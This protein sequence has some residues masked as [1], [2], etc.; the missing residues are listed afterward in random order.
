MEVGDKLSSRP[1]ERIRPSVTYAFPEV[2]REA[3]RAR[4]ENDVR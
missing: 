1:V 3:S 4:E 2:A